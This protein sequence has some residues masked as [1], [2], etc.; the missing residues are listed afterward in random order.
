M[1]NNRIEH[2]VS[3][4]FLQEEEKSELYYNRR[5]SSNQ[6]LVPCR[7]LFFYLEEVKDIRVESVK[8]ATVLKTF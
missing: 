6:I 3:L 5:H 2:K 1:F 7:H 4:R 8:Q